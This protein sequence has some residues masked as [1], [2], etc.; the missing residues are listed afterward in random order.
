M[1]NSGIRRA[2]SQFHGSELCFVNNCVNKVRSIRSRRCESNVRRI[3]SEIT[4]LVLFR[5]PIHPLDVCHRHESY[6]NSSIDY[7]TRIPIHP[8]HSQEGVDGVGDQRT[9]LWVQ[10]SA[11]GLS[12][13]RPSSH[14]VDVEAPLKGPRL[15]LGCPS[16]SLALVAVT[17][18]VA[19]MSRYSPA[20]EDTTRRTPRGMVN[21]HR[22][23]GRDFA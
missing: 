11:P 1:N 9:T 10:V 20:Y 17:A 4:L 19:I 13:G 2:T 21:I 3:E 15:S 5:H 7:L 18:I 8:Y 6:K 16:W 23:V 22:G 14:D 12:V